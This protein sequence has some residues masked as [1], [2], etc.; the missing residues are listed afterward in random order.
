M[1]HGSGPDLQFLQHLCIA[2]FTNPAR[3]CR[4]FSNV[5]GGG[6]GGSGGAGA[7][8]SV[9]LKSQFAGCDLNWG[10]AIVFQ[11]EKRFALC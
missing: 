2:G 11:L 10:W 5:V 7:N 8:H 4:P 1:R 9:D 3:D 6:L